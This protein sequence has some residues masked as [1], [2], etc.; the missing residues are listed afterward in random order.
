MKNATEYIK[1]F[2]VFHGS[3][4]EAISYDSSSRQMIISGSNCLC[5]FVAVKRFFRQALLTVMSGFSETCSA[6]FEDDGAA[7]CVC[8]WVQALNI[9]FR[10]FLLP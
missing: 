4:V 6:Y 5:I 2:E 8:H 7:V 1:G 10:S 9:R 3:G